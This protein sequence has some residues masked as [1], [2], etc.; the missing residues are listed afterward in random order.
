[1]NLLICSPYGSG[2]GNVVYYVTAR[3]Q[4]MG[5][6]C[7]YCSL[8]GKEVE[9]CRKV[10]LCDRNLLK[11][12]VIFRPLYF[13][14]GVIYFWYKAAKYIE[15]NFSTY[16]VIWLHNPSPISFRIPRNMYKKTLIT[17][18]T[19]KHGRHFNLYNR[20]IGKLE[21]KFYNNNNNIDCRFTA[22]SPQVCNELEEIGIIKEKITYIP[23]GVNTNLF[24]P[25][26]AQKILR[27]KFGI[28]EDDLIVLSLGR[29]TEVKQP[30]KLIKVFSVIEEKMKDITLVIA[31][32]GEL[33]EKTKELAE[34]KKLKNVIF[35]GYVD[36]KD[37]PDM[38]AC[39]DY[40][41][42][43]SKYEGQPLTL[44][45][46]MS[47]GLPCIVS[48]IP[49]L[50]IVEDAGCGIVVDFDDTEKAVERII[51]YLRRDNLEHS[52]N[53]REYAVNNLNWKIIAERYLK[54]FE[55]V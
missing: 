13:L 5:I 42:M 49:N 18:H 22:V 8:V 25:S 51:G 52:K 6:N 33:L 19:T 7:T 31:G 23:N 48:N 45:E 55:K 20:V 1:M 16:D 27:K 30:L 4:E 39:S 44:L 47:S 2:A 12:F 26:N 21:K 11:K 29:L 34:Q 28:P 54:E 3:L 43:S 14:Y 50:R 46:A 9:R 35:L 36:E 41:I 24:T 10:E 38:Y 40:Y 32:K 17:I 53:A 15:N 37:K